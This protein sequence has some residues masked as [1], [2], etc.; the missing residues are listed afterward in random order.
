M[1]WFMIAGTSPAFRRSF[2]IKDPLIL[3]AAFSALSDDAIPTAPS[4]GKGCI[5]NGYLWISMDIYGYLWYA[6]QHLPP[7]SPSNVG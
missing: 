2:L 4:V 7:K 1:G 3:E 6:H 5:I